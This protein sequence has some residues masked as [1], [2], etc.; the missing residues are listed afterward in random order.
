[1]RVSFELSD[2]IT[3]IAKK[4]EMKITEASREAARLIKKQKNKTWLREIK[5]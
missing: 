1:M 3:E 5:F 4:N 2:V